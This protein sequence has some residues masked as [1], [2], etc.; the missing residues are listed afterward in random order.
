VQ[1]KA[2]EDNKSVGATFIRRL[3]A[4]PGRSDR[5]YRVRQGSGTAA[6]DFKNGQI[7]LPSLLLATALSASLWW[8]IVAGMR[9]IWLA[10]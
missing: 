7:P 4:D 1:G 6:G 8:G 5:G 9:W 2:V 3:L 10:I